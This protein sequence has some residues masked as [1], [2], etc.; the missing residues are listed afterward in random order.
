[1]KSGSNVI[2]GHTISYQHAA[3]SIVLSLPFSRY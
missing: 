3:K 1:M 2:Q